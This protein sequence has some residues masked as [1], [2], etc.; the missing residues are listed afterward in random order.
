MGG[1]NGFINILC[2]YL[3]LEVKSRFS[4][5]CIT[6]NLSS[7][8]QPFLYQFM[9]YSANLISLF[10]YEEEESYYIKDLKKISP[11]YYIYFYLSIIF[12]LFHDIYLFILQILG[13]TVTHQ[14]CAKMQ[15][16]SFLTHMALLSTN[17]HP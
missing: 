3:K 7:R 6:T 4:I 11:Y 5:T 16:T 14:F 8:G 2:F 15:M 9:S 17:H 1:I 10:E 13:F 12:S